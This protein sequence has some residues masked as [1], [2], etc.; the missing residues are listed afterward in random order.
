MLIAA[1]TCESIERVKNKL[2]GK[3]EARDMGEAGLFLGLSIVRDQSKMLL[4]LHQGRYA[5]DVDRF[6]MA[7]ARAMIAPMAR[8]TRFAVVI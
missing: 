4:W 7:D 6:G 8:E 2:L 5:R 3:F 1:S